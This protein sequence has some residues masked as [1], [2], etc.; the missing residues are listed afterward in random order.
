VSIAYEVVDGI[1]E[2][3]FDR[4]EKLNALTLAMYDELGAAWHAAAE[5]DDVRAIVLT[6][7]GDRAFC[8]GADLTE[9]IPALA[10]DAMDISAWDPAH[11]KDRPLDKP[12]VAAVNGLCLGGGFE[13][14][15]ATDIRIAADTASFAFPEATMGFVPAGGTLVRLSR[16]I[17]HAHAMELLLSAERFDAAH[18][19]RI[20]IVNQVVPAAELREV[21][22]AKAR[23]LA[24]LSPTAL[25]T[26]KESV[27][28]LADLPLDE[29]F[30][31]EARFGQRTF[32]SPDAR[33]ALEAFAARAAPTPPEPRPDAAPATPSEPHPD[34]APTDAKDSR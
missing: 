31:A 22:F 1:A 9:S 6:G 28:V 17:A 13:I 26:I 29:A 8:V 30:A 5:D 32:T 34:A 14:L 19:H 12:I 27:R 23:R 10:S 24:A 18:L 16:Q 4:P 3:R 11:V 21:A 20:G 33:V 15:L 2:I 7:S 25:S